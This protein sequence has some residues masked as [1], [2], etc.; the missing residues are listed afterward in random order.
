MGENENTPDAMD[1]DKDF[2]DKVMRC[3]KGAYPHLERMHGD[4]VKRYSAE[5]SADE[6]GDDTP[7]ANAASPM[8]TPEFGK[9]KPEEEVARMS[10]QSAEIRLANLERKLAQSE[11]TRAEEA[12]RYSRDAAEKEMIQLEAMGYRIDRSWEV[13][14][15]AGSLDGKKPGMSHDQWPAHIERLQRNSRQDGEVGTPLRSQHVPVREDAPS[16]GPRAGAQQNSRQVA[17]RAVQICE[18]DPKIPYEQALEM[19]AK[20]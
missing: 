8:N 4:A 20:P 1:P 18:R 7:A 19:A 15:L 3:M 12:R 5:A 17:E 9:P 6:L 14:Q 2:N 13:D 10:R 11:R 16:R